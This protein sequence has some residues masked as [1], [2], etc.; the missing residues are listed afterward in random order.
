MRG[1]KP[2]ATLLKK[3]HRSANPIN[4]AEPKPVGELARP[5]TAPAHFDEDQRDAWNYALEHAPPGLLKMIDGGVLECWVV[6]H[7][8]HRKAVRAQG[9]EGA[10]LLVRVSANS[11]QM[12]QSPLIPIINRQALIMMKA[13]AEL[14]FSP[15][16]RPR[17]GV[18]LGGGELNGSTHGV[19]RPQGQES[20][21]E[22]LARAPAPQ[23]IH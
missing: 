1:R 8:M 15:T 7:C 20:V 19:A 14:G 3:L 21:D 16:A 4:E 18:T 2:K 10:T 11:R 5:D 23:A 13:A 6:A 22:Y 17:A 12:Q 9:V